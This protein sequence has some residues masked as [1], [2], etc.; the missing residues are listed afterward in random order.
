[1][2]DIDTKIQENRNRIRE[3]FEQ[4]KKV[5]SYYPLFFAYLG[6]IGIYTFDIIVYFFTKQCNPLLIFFGALIILHI[7]VFGYCFYKFLTIIFLKSFGN[8][9]LPV[10]VYIT[11]YNNVKQQNPN[12]NEAQLIEKTKEGYLFT[13]ENEVNNNYNIYS[14]KKENLTVLIKSIL[15][16]FIIYSFLILTFK[17]YIM[18][19]SN[20][21]NSEQQGQQQ[22]QQSSDTTKTSIQQ[23]PVQTPVRRTNEGNENDNSKQLITEKKDST[24]Q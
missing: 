17:F 18:E 6:F 3:L 24:K 16:S 1:M 8:D 22:T 11:T 23:Q 10:D 14:R 2:F 5:E 9:P 21:Q 4:Y 19:D 20:K 7:S 15:V 13:L 12:C